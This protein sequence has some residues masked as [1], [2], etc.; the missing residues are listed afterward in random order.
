MKTTTIVTYIYA[1]LVLVGG[2]VGYVLAGSVASIMASSIFFVLLVVAGYG[3]NKGCNSAYNMS[4][5][6]T[7]LLTLFF[8][9]RFFES[10][11]L[12]PAGIMTL[13]SA[14]TFIYLITQRTKQIS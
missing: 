8:G 13:L 6:L 10:Y 7:L 4:L 14:L 5:V 11:K 3:M 9:Y 1:T 12:A 2:I